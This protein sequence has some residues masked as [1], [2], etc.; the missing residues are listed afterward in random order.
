MSA[1]PPA[2]AR[3][4][5]KVTGISEGL[6]QRRG[7]DIMAALR[8]GLEVPEDQLP[9]WPRGQRFERDVE[10]EAR[11]EALKD[12]RNRR[13]AELELDPGFVM[14]RNLLEEVGK[15]RPKTL[16][17]LAAVEGVRRWQVEAAGEALLGALK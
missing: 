9:R 12:A 8:R 6:A 4:L 13:A 16:E 5:T 17:Q 10:L 1:K 11:V 7:R 3:A 14:S 2:D 15:A